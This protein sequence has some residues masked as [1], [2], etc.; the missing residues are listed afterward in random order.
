MNAL[1]ISHHIQARQKI[2][3][4]LNSSV[5]A[6]GALLPEGHRHDGYM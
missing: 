5:I 2:F 6:L 1:Y 4:N 3:F